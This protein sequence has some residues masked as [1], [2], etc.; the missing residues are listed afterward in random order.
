MKNISKNLK[1]HYESCLEK[2]GPTELA[3]EWRKPEQLPLRFEMM[4]KVAAP[5]VEPFSILDI[6]CGFGLLLDYLIEK[7]F[8]VT[9]YVGVE[10]SPKITE[11]AKSRHP[12]AKFICGDICDTSIS[13]PRC[14]YVV[15]NG[16]FNLKGTSSDEEM[17]EFFET[18][19]RRMYDHANK[20]IAFNVMS[21]YVNFRDESLYYH[22][23]GE[24]I[25]FCVH[26]LSRFVRVYHDYP[27]YEYFTC[28]YKPRPMKQ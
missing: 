27:L 2:F 26:E 28:V 11:V 19:I 6:G 1:E 10:I 16:M 17:K 22:D 25:A 4:L 14:D 5:A 23:P 15:T 13:L 3:M 20:A 12:Q 21:S 18:S 9:E 8:P 7:G 24:T